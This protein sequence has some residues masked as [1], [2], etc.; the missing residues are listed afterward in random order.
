MLERKLEE[1]YESSGLTARP[2]IP[3]TGFVIN[4][5]R[6]NDKSDMAIIFFKCVKLMEY[7]LEKYDQH[8]KLT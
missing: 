7:P 2:S 1:I 5:Y 4:T 3:K 8:H 6:Y